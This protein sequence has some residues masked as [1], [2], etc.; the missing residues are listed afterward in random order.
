MLNSKPDTKN[1][2]QSDTK[3]IPME[4]MLA[5]KNKHKKFIIGIPLEEERNE[6]R[7]GLTPITV[8]LLINNGHEVIIQ[9]NAGNAANFSDNNYSESGA[10]IVNT[11]EEVF[12][13]DIL[14][15]VA[16]LSDAEI[17]LTKN[18]QLII[19]TLNI[20]TQNAEYIRRLTKKK[21]SCLGF[22]FLKDDNDCYPIVRSMSEIAG[23]SSI[24]TA[25]EYLSNVHNGKG[26][27][28]GG[29]TGV[30]PSE[31]V[32]LGAG[33]AGEFAART[34]LGLGAIVKVFDASTWRLKRLQNNL[35]KNIYTSV[36]HQIV[37][38]N[39]LKSADVVIGAI[40]IIEKTS[41]YFVSEEMV[42]LMKKGSVIIDIS[43]DQ[44][45]CIETSRLT[46][47]SNP[48]FVKH[49]VVH[50]CVPNIPSRVARTA[51]YSLSNIFAPLI[52]EMGK[53]GSINN[54][55]KQ[56]IGFRHGLYVFNGTLTNQYIGNRFSLPTQ[57][58]NLLM[59]AF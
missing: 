13:S 55:A 24:L 41:N 56:N 57:H 49:G 58:I 12:R 37:L 25:A 6:N 7:V 38:V 48:V 33:T 3:L 50:Y 1:S 39:A 11:K 54:F 20:A 16:P 51:S 30:N 59:G 21:L 42:K 44:G 17:G 29:I 22:E 15:K 32:I 9:S 27:M 52:I 4:E 28:L 23:S 10:R 26:E 47:H 40:R 36:L 46:T 5:V 35:G 14:L 45:G 19:S 18:N 43:I 8:E 2:V 34:A 53:A 31:V